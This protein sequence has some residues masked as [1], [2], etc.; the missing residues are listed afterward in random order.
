MHENKPQ[1]YDL[2]TFDIRPVLPLI[3]HSMIRSLAFQR[4]D[5]RIGRNPDHAMIIPQGSE[6]DQRVR[7]TTDEILDDFICT[8]IN[9][10]EHTWVHRDLRHMTEAERRI[11]GEFPEAWR[12]LYQ[13][14]H[15]KPEYAGMFAHY[16]RI[17]DSIFLAVPK[18]EG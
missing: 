9:S 13:S 7:I 10:Y 3:D 1:P 18:Y 14:I 4:H 2:L 16:Q 8:A 6:Y 11:H 15:F 12:A 5:Q 17:N